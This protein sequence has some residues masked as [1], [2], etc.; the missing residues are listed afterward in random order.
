MSTGKTA[1]VTSFGVKF[2]GKP[3]KAGI[4][5]S[6][7]GVL[8]K[9]STIYLTL[10][11][12]FLHIIKF[13][14]NKLQDLEE[15]L[16][17][18]DLTSSIP[19]SYLQIVQ[20]SDEN[21]EKHNEREEYNFRIKY[22]TY[23][24][25]IMA[26]S[27]LEKE[28]WNRMIALMKSRLQIQELIRINAVEP[29]YPLSYAVF[30]HGD[31]LEPGVYSIDIRCLNSMWNIKKTFKD[32][33]NFR[34]QL[35]DTFTNTIFPIVRKKLVKKEIKTHNKKS[36]N[37][38]NNE[39][40]GL[41]VDSSLQ[42]KEGSL[43]I[44]SFIR[45]ILSDFEVSQSKQ[46]RSFLEINNVY[47]AIMM[48]DLE[49]L[50]MI[51]KLDKSAVFETTKEGDNILHFAI[52]IKQTKVKQEIIFLIV[53]Y[54][55]T[56]YKFPNLKKLTPV[57]LA[58]ELGQIE[59]IKTLSK[60][61]L[62][63]FNHIH[64]EYFR[65]TPF[66]YSAKYSRLEILKF[67]VENEKKKIK[68]A[69]KERENEN[70]NE[71][72]NE[73]ENENKNENKNEKGTGNEN[74]NRNENENENENKNENE[75]ENGNE[76]ENENGNEK[77]TGNEN[78]GERER[79]K[80][81]ENVNEN[82][83]ENG[84]QKGTGNEKG[85]GEVK[86]KEN[87]KVEQKLE[88]NINIKNEKEN[89]KD[90][91]KKKEQEKKQ[92][93]EEIEYEIEYKSE[94][95]NDKVDKLFLLLNQQETEFKYSA[96]HI[97][98]NQSNL[99]M[100]EYLLNEGIDTELRDLNSYTA[101]ILAIK[102]E[103]LEIIKLLLNNNA[104][105][106]KIIE[107][108]KIS[109]LHFAAKI[110]NVEILKLL[111]STNQIDINDQDDTGR[112]A[113]FYAIESGSIECITLLIGNGAK[114]DIWDK[115]KMNPI[116][117]IIEK[118]NLKIIQYLERN[119]KKNYDIDYELLINKPNSQ[120]NYPIHAATVRGNTEIVKFLLR[121]N[122]DI[123]AQDSVGNTALHIATLNSDLEL[124]S[125]LLQSKAR[126]AIKNNSNEI[127]LLFA[128]RNPIATLAIEIAIVLLKYN[129]PIDAKN[130]ELQQTALQQAVENKN[131]KLA[132]LLVEMG[133]NLN[134]RD[135][136]GNTALHL[137]AKNKM[138]HFSIF[139]AK[140]GAN[141]YTTNQQDKSVLDLIGIG[142]SKKKIKDCWANFLFHQDQNK[143]NKKHSDHSSSSSTST[144]TSTSNLSLNSKAEMKII[145][146]IYHPQNNNNLNSSTHFNLNKINSIKELLIEISKK[147]QFGS[148]NKMK[149]VL[150][151]H[152]LR[153]TTQINLQMDLDLIK[154]YNGDIHVFSNEIY[155]EKFE[156]HDFF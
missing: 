131:L 103:N 91:K 99:K 41:M 96:L 117:F 143:K 119:N 33:I 155:N 136:N 112:T 17:K 2:S 154:K 146:I 92:E 48:E 126:V 55:P 58:I 69:E 98:T 40:D 138:E 128:S 8:N 63:D 23:H 34:K 116:H 122:A 65:M 130:G 30:S 123:N 135:L 88:K 12:T 87:P 49:L 141:P 142:K 156:F 104:D 82:E 64:M 76:N 113:L 94:N 45:D 78:G 1:S 67:I 7:S 124:I 5:Q 56:L 153:M 47:N 140:R 86:E 21:I 79:E 133:A 6:K 18:R 16:K 53:D 36:K 38:N 114:M 43:F 61:E 120:N 10:S 29:K 13:E 31:E 44:H 149:L 129:S 77:G 60:I 150:F 106:T 72:E 22:G 110:G 125:F 145:K 51:F 90:Q 93:Q 95:E 132:R 20:L 89:Y 62:I 70:R 102:N 139:L 85:N 144:I 66:L 15:K 46:V 118:N 35:E 121:N 147:F 39:N 28:N 105:P 127:P 9:K 111:I 109:T 3:I 24:L 148:Q 68:Q 42:E 25:D 134:L 26:K 83:N 80:K 84:N 115:N 100:V 151:N 137:C 101:L 75:N 74:E 27:D 71:N 107:E 81:N 152:Q 14:K 19:L 73:N 4:F 52:N 32:F 97:A 57:L 37:N 108:N 59:T 11:Q 50:E 54:F